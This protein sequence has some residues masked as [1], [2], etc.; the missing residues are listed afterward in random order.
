MMAQVKPPLTAIKRVDSFVVSRKHVECYDIQDC[1]KL[2]HSKMIPHTVP[3]D[4]WLFEFTK[5]YKTVE[6]H[7]YAYMKKYDANMEGTIVEY[8]FAK[9][10]WG[11]PYVVNSLGFSSFLRPV[12]HTLA[13]RYYD[14]DLKNAQPCIIYWTLVRNNLP[15]PKSLELYVTDRELIIKTLMEELKFTPDQRWLIKQLFISLFFMGTWIGFKERCLKRNIIVPEKAPAYV[16]QLGSDLADIATRL[17]ARNPELYKSA[18]WKRKESNDSS[19]HKIMRTFLA[20]WAQNQEFLVVDSVMGFL[21]SS[22]NL[23]NTDTPYMDTSFEFD[24]FKLSRQKVDAFPGG[25]PA[26]LQLCNEYVDKCIGLPLLFESKELDEAIDISNIEIPQEVE[27]SPT[28]L[29]EE[30]TKAAVEEAV[31]RINLYKTSHMDAAILLQNSD[32]A[33]DFLY[34]RKDEQWF[35]WDGFNWEKG[36]H[37]FFTNFRTLLIN[38]VK[39]Q[40]KEDVWEEAKVKKSLNNLTAFIGSASYMG[41]IKKVGE[42]FL[43]I[44]NQE[45]DMNTDIL[46]FK[47]GVLDIAKKEFRD[48]KREDYVQMSC[49]YNFYPDLEEPEYEAEIWRIFREI[50]PDPELLEF[51]MMTLAT[52]LTGRNVEKFFIFNGSG[53]NGKSLI[54]IMMK[55]CLGDY[56]YLAP[57][58][59]LIESQKKTG[60]GDANPVIA[61]L[62]KKRWVVCSEPPKN[63]PIQ[64]STIKALTGNTTTQGRFLHKNTR[65]IQL[66]L[67]L[68][69][70]A[71]SVPHMSESAEFADIERY[72]DYLFE[73][74]FVSDE[75]EVNPEKHIYKKNQGLKKIQWWKDRRNAL[76][77]ILVSYVYKLHDI[78]YDIGRVTPRSV[79]ERT[80]RYT[81]DSYLVHRLFTANYKIREESDIVPYAEW[82]VDHTL[83]S[84][85]SQ[86][87]NCE[88]WQLLPP[89]IK[90]NKE[91]SPENMKEWFRKHEPFSKLVYSKNNQYFLRGYR[92]LYPNYYMDDATGTDLED[93][94]SQDTFSTVNV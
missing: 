51:L 42:T 24:G 67:S 65:D 46:N 56:F 2:L 5:S 83:Q 53:R 55:V 8:R 75:N 90:N 13:K 20:L 77:K 22:T 73:S 92:K 59:L 66:H 58:A 70:E 41:N 64:N 69:L 93:N 82:D 9:H 43:S 19:P 32:Q 10:M 33:D 47:N 71:N 79:I 40:I 94:D 63:L 87:R 39:K 88:N 30:A 14:I 36:H 91:N 23:M 72:L 81:L 62:D 1:K 86:L 45:F 74:R 29:D 25:L 54:T 85:V 11:R 80:Q 76:M 44:F 68:C 50:I 34:I 49:G 27:Y 61:S 17:K 26:V 18:M 37:F 6:D 16:N 38:E 21:S 28:K 12:R 7:L 60:S 31:M 89:Y 3:E 15:A 84:I 78:E 4:H 57:S 48:R 52:G 35:T